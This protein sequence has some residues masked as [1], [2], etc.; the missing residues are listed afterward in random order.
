MSILRIRA[1]GPVFWE[2]SSGALANRYPGL[3]LRQW[4]TTYIPIGSRFWE[5][6][7]SSDACF[8]VYLLRFRT[9]SKPLGGAKPYLVRLC[10]RFGCALWGTGFQLWE[11]GVVDMGI[12]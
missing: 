9:F 4:V 5:T 10:G 1:I 8:S 6:S 7:L 12:R 3:G 2:L 11:R